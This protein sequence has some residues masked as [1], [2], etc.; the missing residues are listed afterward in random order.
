MKNFVL[1]SFLTLSFFPFAQ[2]SDLVLDIKVRDDDRNGAPL[3]NARV[4][5]YQHNE[6]MAEGLSD[7]AGV[8]KKM[9][10]PALGTYV[11]KVDKDG[12]ALKYGEV[13]AYFEDQAYLPSNI[14]FPMIVG[15]V[16]PN[17]Q[18]DY[19]FLSE[20]PMIKFHLDSAG[21]QAW[22]EAYTQSMLEKVKKC[23]AGWTIEQVEQYVEP[24]DRGD[25]LTKAGLFE[26]AL[27]AYEAAKDADDNPEIAVA[28]KNC[29]IEKQI[30]ETNELMYGNFIQIGDQMLEN[31]R[32][33]EAKVYFHKAL[34]IKPK[35]IYPQE[36]IAQCEAFAGLKKD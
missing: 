28:I 31:N 17:E 19:A 21:N 4:R 36:K 15:L 20:R 9:T 27:M 25:S 24:R 26:E 2:K 33:D 14:K 22:D 6:L 32:Y 3:E 10:V 7:T 16:Q 30:T 29:Y 18:E 13:D 11:I 12:Y 23:Q 1:L 34:E 5:V 35:E 8:V